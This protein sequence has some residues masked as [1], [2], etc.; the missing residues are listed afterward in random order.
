MAHR[1]RSFVRT[2]A[3]RS[4]TWVAG[5]SESVG[6]IQGLFTAIPAGGFAELAFVGVPAVTDL[7]I[8]RTLGAFYANILDAGQVGPVQ[9]AIGLGLAQSDA[10]AAGVDA[11]PTAMEDADWDGWFYHRYFI[12][13]STGS[14]GEQA[15]ERFPIDS[16][17][18]RRMQGDN[19]QFFSV[20]LVNLD[21]S[22]PVSVEIHALL[23]Q[24]QK[25]I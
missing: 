1:R 11:L 17:A 7:T 21:V 10:L 3:K 2:K 12:L 13:E 14:G 16:K 8:L 20:Q 4:I 9:M 24:L 6:G 18:M 23:R 22:S 19:G 5:T 25:Y 15:F